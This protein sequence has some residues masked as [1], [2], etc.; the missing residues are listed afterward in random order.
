M[1]ASRWKLAL[2]GALA[3]ALSLAGPARAEAACDTPGFAYAGLRSA[4]SVHGI[5]AWL[6]PLQSPVVNGAQV[7]ASVGV[8]RATVA[9]KRGELRAGLL[10][11]TGEPNRMYYEVLLNGSWRVYVGP[12][13]QP[14]E[15]HRVALL[16]TA[17]RRGLWR[18]WF[19]G[20]PASKPFVL[21][22]R[23]GGHTAL[24]AAETWSD[25]TGTCDS[26]R[27][28]FARVAVSGQR[29][30]WRRL[31][32][33]RVI[34]D[35][36]FAV[37]RSKK[38]NTFVAVS[39]NEPAP[40]P[41]P[42]AEPAPPPAPTP[43]PGE[44]EGD[45][46]TGDWRQWSGVHHRTGGNL[47][48]QF[49]VLTDPLRQG[50]FAARFTVRPGDK[51]GA[52][53]G[54]RSEVLWVDSGEG[55]GDEYWYAWSTLFPTGWTE[56]YGWG[57]FLQWHSSFPIPPPVSFNARGT[58]AEVVVDSGPLNASRTAGTF[59]VRYPLLDKL[60]KGL[61]NDFIARIRWSGTNGAIT[62]WHRVEGENGYV[63]RL[64]VSGIPTLQSSGG[65]TSD[66][67][68]KLGLYRNA[69]TKTD[70]VYHD[71][72]HRW[73]SLTPPPELEDVL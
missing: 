11:V 38:K 61:W 32:R 47:A 13:V 69:D 62:V 66:N 59:R 71:G 41:A 52:T 15:Q 40:A 14:G 27:Y 29:G 24:A 51:F 63:K 31:Y 5:R 18:V 50:G 56:P 26:F 54:E 57:I 9:G 42:P 33:S 53:S 43:P 34:A 22:R 2:T 49:A 72:F 68:I 25:G 12:Y 16:E 45:W 46:E 6:V 28:R 44:F 8:G 35:S 39:S 58:Y 21:G 20:R 17:T 3:A 64:D 4:R 73:Q 19:D 70:V 48:D 10:A 30:H 36:G 67:Y 60:S 23:P 37:L 65:V 1:L 55:E 7:T